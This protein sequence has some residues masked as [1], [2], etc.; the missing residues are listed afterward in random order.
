MSPNVALSRRLSIIRKDTRQTKMLLRKDNDIK[1]TAFY[2]KHY[3][4]MT[5][6]RHAVQSD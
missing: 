6:Q 5:L 4:T 1:N 3:H 2:V